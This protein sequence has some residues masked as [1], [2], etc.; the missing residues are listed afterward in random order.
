[1]N[2]LGSLSFQMDKLLAWHFLG[3][4]QLAAY[5]VAT[6]PP[7]Q[8]RY[9]N[10]IIN[11]VSVPKYSRQPMDQ[12]RRTIFKKSLVLLGFSVLLVIP[13]WLAAPWLFELVFPKYVEYVIYSQVFSLVI[14]FFPVILIQGVLMAKKQTKAL[15]WIQT[16]FPLIKIALLFITLPLFGLWGIFITLFILEISRLILSSWFFLRIPLDA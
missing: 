12:I 13:Y 8:L 6:A 15:Y 11:T 1:M 7:Q 4:V 10:K 2:V 5:A 16:M 14:L 9:F 3:P